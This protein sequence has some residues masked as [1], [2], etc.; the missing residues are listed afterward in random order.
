[1]RYRLIV[2]TNFCPHRLSPLFGAKPQPLAAATIMRRNQ[3]RIA[4][5]FSF[6]NMAQIARAILLAKAIA[7][8]IFGF[9]SNIG[10]AMIPQRWTCARRDIAPM[11]SKWRMSAWSAFEPRPSRSHPDALEMDD[12]L[13]DCVTL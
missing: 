2:S 13:R 11:I 4:V 9:F 7:T 6:V 5:I 12:A 10:P 1:M 3:C 8:S